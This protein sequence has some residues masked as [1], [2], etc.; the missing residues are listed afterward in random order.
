MVE[1]TVFALKSGK[2]SIDEI[3]LNLAYNRVKVSARRFATNPFMH[4]QFHLLSALQDEENRLKRE[5]LKIK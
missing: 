5:R 1:A 4:D 2:D 3:D